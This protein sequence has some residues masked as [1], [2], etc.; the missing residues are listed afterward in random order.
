MHGVVGGLAGLPFRPHSKVHRACEPP[1]PRCTLHTC[2]WWAL[3]MT[4]EHIGCMCVHTWHLDQ[5]RGSV[6]GCKLHCGEALARLDGQTEETGPQVAV[7][8]LPRAHAWG[9]PSAGAESS[10]L[11]RTWWGW[12]TRGH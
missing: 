9:G 3:E 5:E 6:R 10:Q 4:P 11:D 12:F 7:C 1:L 2:V 8:L